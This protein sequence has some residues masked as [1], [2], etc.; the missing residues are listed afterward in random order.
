MEQGL[1]SYATDFALLQ[2]RV[3]QAKLAT[4][5]RNLKGY[6]EGLRRRSPLTL[7]QQ[8]QESLAKIDALLQEI[9]ATT[10]TPRQ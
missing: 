5:L 10:Q 4:V 6:R 9:Q 2:T 8:E 1:S 3:G 7:S